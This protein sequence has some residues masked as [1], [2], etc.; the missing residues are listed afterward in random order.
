MGEHVAKMTV[1]VEMVVAGLRRFFLCPLR[2]RLT[3]R[4]LDDFLVKAHRFVNAP[5]EG[6]LTLTR[7]NG[8]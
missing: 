2:D 5:P 1:L 7:A 8:A 4:D 3:A 6:A